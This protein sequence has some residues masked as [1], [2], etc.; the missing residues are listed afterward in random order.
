MSPDLEKQLRD[1]LRAVDPPAGFAARVSERTQPRRWQ[2]RW[3][4]MQGQWASAALAASVLATLVLGYGWQMHRERQGQQAR[5]QLIE[6][7]RVTG[8]KLDLAY[9]GVRDA[10]RPGDDAGA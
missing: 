6:A 7:L 10:S 8:A 2:R 1:A 3:L 9:R 4:P 5:Q